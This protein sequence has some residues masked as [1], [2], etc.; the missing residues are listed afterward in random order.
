MAAW[1]RL[2]DGAGVSLCLIVS[3]GA[4]GPY[5]LSVHGMS[6][7]VMGVRSNF[8]FVNVAADD[9]VRVVCGWSSTVQVART[10]AVGFLVRYR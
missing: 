8:D 9:P 4:L 1:C 3:L 10:V 2:H 6:G 5:K 7:V